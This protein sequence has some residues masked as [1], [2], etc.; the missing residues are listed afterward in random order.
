MD[1]EDGAGTSADADDNTVSLDGMGVDAAALCAMEQIQFL[2]EIQPHGFLL[3]LSS[4]W[5]LRRASDNVVDFFGRPSEAL[6]GQSAADLLGRRCLHD[7]RSELQISQGSSPHVLTEVTIPGRDQPL[8]LIIHREGESVIV[9]GEPASARDDRLQLN[10]QA[11]L[12]QVRDLTSLDTL[13]NLAVRHI[14]ALT[15]YDRVM[16]YRFHADESGEVIAEVRR[17]DLD[18]YLGLHYPATDIPAQARALYL[19]NPIRQIADVDAVTVPVSPRVGA[20]G[21]RIDLSLSTLRAVSP[22]HIQYLKNM[23]VTASMSLSIVVEGR[24]WGLISCHHQSPRSLPAPIQQSLAF[25]ANILSMTIETVVRGRVVERQKAARDRHARMLSQVSTQNGSIDDLFGLLTELGE[26]L[27]ATGLATYVDGRLRLGGETPTERET[28]DLMRF[29]NGAAASRVYATHALSKSHP[30]A[31]DYEANV[32]G[33]LAIPVSRRPRDYV[34]FFRPELVSTVRWGGEPTKAVRRD[35]TGTLRLTP[36]ASFEEWREVVRLQSRHWSDI[37]CELAEG[38]RISLLEI[39]L[40]LTDQAEKRRKSSN[41][42]QDLLIAE[43]NHRVRNILNLIIGLVRQCAEGATDIDDFAKDVNSRVHALSR[44]H[45]QLTSSGWGARS[46]TNMIKVEAGA[47][48]GSGADRVTVLGKDMAIQPDAFAT[49]ALVMHELIT[50]AA[51]YGA[52]KDASGTVSI[53]IDELSDEGLAIYWKETGGAPVVAPTRRGFGS[54]IIERAIPHELGGEA[55]VAFEPDGLRAAFRLPPHLVTAGESV[56]VQMHDRMAM[57]L[58]SKAINDRITGSVLLVEDN[59][60]IA[61][62]AEAMLQSLGASDIQVASTVA[63]ALDFLA[64]QK[65]DFAVLDY[66]LGREQSTRVAE[67]LDRLG[68][69]F[70]FATG[71]GDTSMIDER[72]RQRPILTKPYSAGN[73]IAAYVEL[74]G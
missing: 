39:M 54:T 19:R 18:P 25:Y 8:D 64:A 62:E 68:V 57:G 33:I 11:M 48:L 63:S 42:Q 10:I 65:P 29:L 56:D 1:L 67:E 34:V 7:I 43:L 3:Q 15:G 66:N 58:A 49:V 21:D 72:F 45:D 26:E 36:R 20:G 17:R 6:I 13:T 2:G 37:D 14:R 4:D 9:E 24:L 73:V 52:L 69:P 41:D 16:F 44:A 50:N 40:Q 23:G 70:V 59:L 51:K 74:L 61:L 32:A 38:L 47:Y 5:L 35:E 22:V 30:P 28:L 27:G 12:A 71:Y 31:A 46:L 60:L 55:S 53:R